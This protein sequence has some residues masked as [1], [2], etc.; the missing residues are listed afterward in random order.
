[1]YTFYTIRIYDKI[2][3][4]MKKENI[5]LTVL[6]FTLAIFVTCLTTNYDYDLFARLEVGE[7][8]FK[9]HTVLKHDP[10]SYTPTL[11]WFDHEWGSGVFFYAFLNL[12]GPAGLIILNAILFFITT[13]FLLKHNKNIEYPLLTGTLFLFLLNYEAGQLI[14]CQAFT[15]MLTSLT[16]YILEKFKNQNSKLIWFLPVIIA[17]WC[18]LHGGVAAGLGII[19]IYTI[20]HLI[21]RKT[22]A[23]K[24]V[25]AATLSYA[26]LLI[27]PYGIRYVAY[28]LYTI[29]VPRTNIEDWISVFHP[30]FFVRYL[31]VVVIM[32]SMLCCKIYRN[33]KT[34][35]FD[36]Y[37]YSIILITMFLSFLHLKNIPL[38]TIILFFFASKDINYYF[39]QIKYFK[40][41]NKC[42]Y[43]VIPILAIAIPFTINIPRATHFCFPFTEVEFIKINNI[44]G[45]IIA[46]FGDAGYISYKLYPDNKI[47]IDGR[48]DGVYPMK[49]FY[50]YINFVNNKN[51]WTNAIDNYPTDIIIVSKTEKIYDIL[52]KELHSKWVEIFSSN[53]RGIFVKKENVKSFY[54]EPIYDINYYRNNLF[55]TNFVNYIKRENYD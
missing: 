36:F 15:F 3:I 18:N 14:K 9:L 7:I 46:P 22:N 39:N 10:F 13:F 11:Y 44:K 1:M 19:S 54:K 27:N 41:I 50:D 24:L 34:K 17:L 26:A 33:I 42:L 55:K 43:I 35:N 29:T 4:V 5:I 8:F 6:L 47:F 45:N 52:K 40:T 20:I 38:A 12:L 32:V 51:G 30:R 2:F 23:H 21:K 16:I 37:E 31:P 48:Y 28:L 49:V 53:Q 25:L